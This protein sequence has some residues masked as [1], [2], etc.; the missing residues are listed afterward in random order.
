MANPSRRGQAGSE[1]S[2]GMQSANYT[3]FANTHFI[4]PYG[5]RLQQTI[6]A[7]TTSVT[8][9]AGI[10]FVYTGPYAWTNGILKALEVRDDMNINSIVDDFEIINSLPKA[11]ENKFYLYGGEKWRIFHFYD[12]IHIYGSQR[13][14]ED[15]YVRW[16]EH[17][18]ITGGN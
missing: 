8:I 7:G 14:K 3:P 4:L 1:V 12:V 13:W 2:T 11:I 9:P 15:S 6:N 16:I 18:L 5:L 10:T 17:G